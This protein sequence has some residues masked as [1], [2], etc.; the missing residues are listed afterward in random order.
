MSEYS[1]FKRIVHDPMVASFEER[2]R[3]LSKENA[4]LH[5]IMAVRSAN[6]I[7]ALA[8]LSKENERLRILVEQAFRDGISYSQNVK[9]ESTDLAWEQSRI[10]AAL[11]QTNAGESK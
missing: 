11:E 8:A 3:A 4:E 9:V 2:L 6:E 10:R 7:D 1:D 5:S